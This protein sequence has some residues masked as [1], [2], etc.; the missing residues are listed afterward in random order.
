LGEPVTDASSARIRLVA[1]DLDGT[2]IRSDGTV[3]PRVVAALAAVEELGLPVVF[4]T[5][6]PPRWMAEVAGITSH[7]GIAICANGALVYDLHT[8]TVLERFELEPALALEAVRRLRTLMPHAVFAVESADGFNH[9]AAYVPRWPG[10][11]TLTVDVAEQLLTGPV[12]KLLVRDETSGGDAMLELALA[13]LGDL[14]T[15]T[16]SNP[17]DC[18]LEISAPG[19]TKAS[20]LARVAA[21]HGIDASGVLAFG[22][23]PN[24]VPMLE[25]AGTAYAMDGGHPDVLALVPAH[26]DSVEDDGVAQVLERLMADGTI[27][28]PAGRHRGPPLD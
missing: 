17:L 10:Q 16:H 28:S 4:V 19:V 26:A 24:D 5:G 21:E 14:V 20:T 9:E 3:S 18:M 22:D 27:R 1:T 8:E 25:W 13:T 2:I 11:D 7:H 15:V 12:A 6:R 23:Q